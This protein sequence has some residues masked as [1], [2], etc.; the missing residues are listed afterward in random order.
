ME[1]LFKQ[2]FV[3]IDVLKLKWKSLFF[4]FSSDNV[5]E[6]DRFMRINRELRT[7]ECMMGSSIRILIGNYGG[8]IETGFRKYRCVKVKMKKPLLCFVYG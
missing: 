3:N 5:E 2:V 4:V 8:I 7:R 1:E 6:I